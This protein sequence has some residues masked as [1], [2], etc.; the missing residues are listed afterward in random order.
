MA[1]DP[2]VFDPTDPVLEH[3][4][5]QFDF[6]ERYLHALEMILAVDMAA[7]D[8]HVQMRLIATEALDRESVQKWIDLDRPLPWLD[9]QVGPAARQARDAVLAM[10]GVT[11]V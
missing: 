10:L 9:E 11:P 5:I 4:A 3:F 6:R 2:I 7:A 1:D 8:A